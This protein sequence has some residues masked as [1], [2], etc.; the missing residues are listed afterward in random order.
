[1]QLK[2]KVRRLWIGG[3]ALDVCVKASVLDAL[4]E[5]FEVFILKE[6]VCPVTAEG[7]RNAFNFMRSAGAGIAV[8]PDSGPRG[9]M[10]CDCN[11]KISLRLFCVLGR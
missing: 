2:G 5:G 8:Y 9:W 1:M 6:G 7:G 11:K 10:S 4:E 3:L